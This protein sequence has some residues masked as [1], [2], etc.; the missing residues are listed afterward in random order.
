MG[1]HHQEESEGIQ[2]E[3]GAGPRHHRLAQRPQQ[4]HWDVLTEEADRCRQKLL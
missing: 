3:E 4:H 1:Q 2:A